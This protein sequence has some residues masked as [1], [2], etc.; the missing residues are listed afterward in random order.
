MDI[1][2]VTG[3]HADRSS[4]YRS[5]RYDICKHCKLV[6]TCRRK[7]PSPKKAV[8]KGTVAGKDVAIGRLVGVTAVCNPNYDSLGTVP[9]AGYRK[10][11]HRQQLLYVADEKCAVGR[12]RGPLTGSRGMRVSVGRELGNQGK[13]LDGMA[14]RCSG[15][16]NWPR[17]LTLPLSAIVS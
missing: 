3:F 7:P 12:G 14:C 17:L 8:K 4:G 5:N 1:D 11:C 10:A 2:N 16:C 6:A 15:F 13:W 9:M